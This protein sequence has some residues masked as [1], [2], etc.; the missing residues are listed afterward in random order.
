MTHLSQ[1][2]LFKTYFEFCFEKFST[3][4]WRFYFFY[5][6]PIVFLINHYTSPHDLPA[7]PPSDAAFWPFTV[8]SYT[9]SVVSPYWLDFRIYPANTLKLCIWYLG[10][11]RALL[12]KRISR[13][14]TVCTFVQFQTWMYNDTRCL[15][16]IPLYAILW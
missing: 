5:L 2:A 10:T 3:C 1:N 4:S 12:L 11:L 13:E 16:Y 8:V 7:S 14:Q 15:R 9:T 6:L